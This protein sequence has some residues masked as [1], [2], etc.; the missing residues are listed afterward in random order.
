MTLSTVPNWIAIG[1]IVLN[2][3]LIYRLRQSKKVRMFYWKQWDNFEGKYWSLYKEY[4]KKLTPDE[5]ARVQD[6]SIN[7]DKEMWQIDQKP[8]TKPI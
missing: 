7:R 2:L 6:I 5:L 4:I 3:F 1:S 8:L